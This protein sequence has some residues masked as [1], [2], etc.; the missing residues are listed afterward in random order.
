MIQNR[1]KQ[2]RVEKGLT[3]ARVAKQIGVSQPNYQR[4]ESGSAEI[5]EEKLKKLAFA[6]KATPEQ[7]LG[8]H[9]PI[10]AGFYDDE[11][12]AELNYYGEVAIH[13]AGGGKPLVLSI[14]DAAFSK[15]HHELQTDRSYVWVKSL[16]NQ[17]VLIRTKAIADLYLASDASDTFGPEHHDD[18]SGYHENHFSLQI[19]DNRDW[20]IIEELEHGDAEGYA[21]EDVE[22]VQKMIMITDEQYQEF[23]S[24]GRIKPEDLEA[25]KEKNRE[26]T[27]RRFSY[28]NLTRYQLSTG[29]YRE[30]WLDGSELYAAF[31][32]FAEDLDG[33]MTNDLIRVECRNEDQYIFL[34][35]HAF[36]YV[37]MPTH[38]FEAGEI[39][40]VAEEIDALGDDEPE[41]KRPVKK[42]AKKGA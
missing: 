37:M 15:L 39:D 20:E 41:T 29:K 28:A 38:K 33:E 23:V 22:R 42:T 19:P 2:Y 32:D 1:L 30:V 27:E 4:W 34:N 17:T 25:E 6:L 14:S 35:K 31:W 21:P 24:D 26:E 9:P 8:R 3:Q 16:C 10:K 13:F 36:D 7:L 40:Q 5:P 18:D 11:I 12:G